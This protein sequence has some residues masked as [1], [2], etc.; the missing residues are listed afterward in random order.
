MMYKI[1]YQHKLLQSCLKTVNLVGLLTFHNHHVRKMDLFK[2]SIRVGL[3]LA[4][5]IIARLYLLCKNKTLWAIKWGLLYIP[6]SPYCPPQHPISQHR[7]LPTQEPA[8]PEGN[9]SS[10]ESTVKFWRLGGT[11]TCRPNYQL[12]H[13]Q[14]S[15]IFSCTWGKGKHRGHA[16]LCIDL[17]LGSTTLDIEIV[18]W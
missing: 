5:I 10:A 9:P 15:L 12:L 8:A 17:H 2:F 13:K 11:S 3:S 14:T 4:N 7:F 18:L 16:E 6:K 1:C